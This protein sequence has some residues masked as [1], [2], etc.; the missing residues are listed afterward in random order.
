[1]INVKNSYFCNKHCIDFKVEQSWC[2]SG[3]NSLHLWSWFLSLDDTEQYWGGNTDRGLEI[4]I[5]YHKDSHYI[6]L[7]LSSCSFQH[8]PVSLTYLYC[9]FLSKDF[10]PPSRLNTNSW[11]CVF[12]KNTCDI[13]FETG[14]LYTVENFTERHVTNGLTIVPGAA[15]WSDLKQTR[16]KK[17]K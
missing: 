16:R 9:S 10:C 8:G 12:S 15:D 4:V 14:D 1:M 3:S 17:R 13:F 11:L 7:G 5:L 6:H 2:V